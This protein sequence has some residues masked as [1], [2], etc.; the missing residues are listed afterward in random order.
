MDYSKLFPDTKSKKDDPELASRLVAPEP[1]VI[2]ESGVIAF[3][4]V[5]SI[6]DI[7]G[8]PNNTVLLF[9]PDKYDLLECFSKYSDLFGCTVSVLSG[10]PAA[11]Y[12]A[13]FDSKTFALERT[14]YESL[15]NELIE[16]SRNKAMLEDEGRTSYDKERSQFTRRN[17]S[18][19]ELRG[20]TI[21]KPGAPDK[22]ELAEAGDD[23]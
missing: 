21:A 8:L 23:E 18:V 13:Q 19:K 12:D 14:A 1:H 5:E 16:A 6:K 4:V 3:A 7:V 17:G 2:P 15:V 10:L 20:I 11:D 22:V 9:S